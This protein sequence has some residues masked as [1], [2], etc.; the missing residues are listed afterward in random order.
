MSDP[1][2]IGGAALYVRRSPLYV[3][4]SQGLPP[5]PEAAGPR[6]RH[7]AFNGHAAHVR[8]LFREL[9]PAERARHADPEIL[10]QAALGSLAHVH[11]VPGGD[12]LEVGQELE[13]LESVVRLFVSDCCARG[14]FPRELFRTLLDW[15]D[16][17]ART[18][19]LMESRQACDLAVQ[20][21]VASFPDI[22]P[23][24]QVH[25]ARA[26]LMLG[27]TEAAHAMLLATYQRRDRIADRNAIPALLDL[28]G[29]ASL[30]TR[31]A[32]QFKRLLA[33]RLR[34]FHTNVDERRAIVILIKTVNR[35]IAPLLASGDLTITDKL[36]WLTHWVLLGASR[37]AGWRPVAHLLETCD[38]GSAYVR[39]YGR[40][41]RGAT[42]GRRDTGTLVTRAMGGVGDLLMMTPGLRALKAMRGRPSVLAIPR[43]F[44]PLFDGNDAVEL[45]DIDGDLDPDG[46]AEW[47]NLTDCPAARVE[48]RTAPDVSTNRIEL[49]ARGMGITGWRLKR[50]DRRPRYVVSG[51]ESRWRDR[52]FDDRGLRGAAVIGVQPRTD[53]AYRDVPHIGEIVERLAGQALVLV[54]GRVGTVASHP[55]ITEADGLTIRESFALASGCDVLLTPDSAFFHLAGALDLPC[56]GLFGPTD[57]RV[58]GHDYPR[59]RIL[60]ARRTLPCVPC[61]R[62][63]ATPCALTGLRSSACLGEITPAEVAEAVRAAAA[64]LPRRTRAA[65]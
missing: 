26:R 18:S 54:F 23:W 63:D 50:M 7:L 48:S 22:W 49:F 4:R 34:A 60:D 19:R 41:S 53:E 20:L 2:P 9:T 16:E 52:F 33:D 36:L 40:P 64:S 8:A 35:G 15:A 37:H 65:R 25:G 39:Q 42:G 43:R 29:T 58:R 5:A 47:F 12:S 21:G 11:A 44:F 3:R 38:T 30:Q 61:W 10:R 46:Y 14:A 13:F 45:R 27:E 32:P 24:M 55:R 51:A 17:L 57:G 6:L 56:V 1:A 28:L 62:N 59:A 31:R